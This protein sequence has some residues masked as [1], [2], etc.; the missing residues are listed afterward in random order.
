MRPLGEP[1]A[2][3]SRDLGLLLALDVR[4]PREI[5]PGSAESRFSK[6]LRLL[7]LW[8]RTTPTNRAAQLEKKGMRQRIG[9]AF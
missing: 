2:F 9:Q 5:E 8:G 1:D 4:N 6:T 7:F 3:P